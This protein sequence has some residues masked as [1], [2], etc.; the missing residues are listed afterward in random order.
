MKIS[1]PIAIL[2]IG[3]LL[4]ILPA[5]IVLAKGYVERQ[6]LEKSDRYS[7]IED[8]KNYQNNK[9]EIDREER[10]RREY[11]RNKLKEYSDSLTSESRLQELNDENSVLKDL[12]ELSDSTINDDVTNKTESNHNS[13]N[14]EEKLSEINKNQ[15]YYKSTPVKRIIETISFGYSS[16]LVL[17]ILIFILV[18]A[19]II[20]RISRNTKQNNINTKENSN[21]ILD[22]YKAPENNTEVDLSSYFKEDGDNNGEWSERS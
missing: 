8:V 16:V 17:E 22:Y 1:K 18:A 10:K 15:E 3:V 13:S 14:P 12:D 2:I 20:Y 6:T 19:G 9:A 11:N 5:E 4:T 21:S 7:T